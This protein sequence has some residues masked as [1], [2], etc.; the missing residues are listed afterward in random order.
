MSQRRI[1]LAPAL[2]QEHDCIC[3][4]QGARVP[5]V[6]RK[7]ERDGRF[8]LVGEAFVEKFMHGE[9]QKYSF[10]KGGIVLI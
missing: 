10:S 7:T 1:G 6:V 5:F 9:L 2:A 4:L 3:L 8:R